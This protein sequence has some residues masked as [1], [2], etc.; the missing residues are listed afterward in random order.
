MLARLAANS[1]ECVA[2][3]VYRTERDGAPR[4]R[5]G[6]LRRAIREKAPLSPVIA[7]VK[8][9]SPSA[10]V[11]RAAADPA[12]MAASME[13]GGACAVSVLTQPR[14][15]GGSPEFLRRAR[16][17][18]DVPVVM[19]D[20]V[21]DP[22]QVDAG[23]AAGADCVLLMQSLADGGHVDDMGSLVDRAHGAGMDALLEAH[24][25][26]EFE[27]ALSSG[28]DVLGINNRD[29]DTLEVDLGVTERVLR[30]AARDG[31]PVVSESGVASPADVSRLRRAGA[32][33]FLVGSGIMGAADVE[34]RVR[35][36]VGAR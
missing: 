34:G 25:A 35:G 20:I 14:L 6:L 2:E 27:R 26:G 23:A 11:L 3:G 12:G 17:A 31:R 29:L 9:S 21:V 16:A 30:G 18:V 36:L 4:P 1:R 15:F 5:R 7:E 19:K 10:G 22:A 33:A 24:T 8:F 28:A 32:D 13:A